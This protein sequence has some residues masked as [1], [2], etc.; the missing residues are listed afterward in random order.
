MKAYLLDTNIASALWDELDRDHPDAL[1]FVTDVASIGGL[2][3]VSRITIAEIEYGLKLYV[4]KQPVRSAKAEAAM[5]IYK[6]VRDIGKGTTEH[7]ATIRAELFRRYAPKDAKNRIRQ[8]RPEQ[9]LDKTT[10]QFLG[11]QENDL[12][13]AAIAVERNMVLVT[14]DRMVRI[15]AVTPNLTIAKWKRRPAIPSSPTPLLPGI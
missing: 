1:K 8:V 15:Q 14:D 9:L 7:Y 3:Y 4:S 12:W 5:R 11:I 2:V 10:G 6:N 13:I